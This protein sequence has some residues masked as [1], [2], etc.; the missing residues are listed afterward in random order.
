MN[1]KLFVVAT[2]IGNLSDITKRAV[3][4]LERVNCIA[5]EDTRETRG[6]LQKLHIDCDKTFISNNGYNEKT[7][8]DKVVSLLLEGNDVAVVSDAGMPGI[9]DPGAILVQAA[10]QAGIEVTGVCGASAVVTAVAVSGFV[11]SNSDFA[12]AGFFPR[13]KNEIEQKL[14]FALGTGI[15]TFVFYEAPLRITQT[16]E[17]IQSNMPEARLCLCNDL[18]KLYERIYRGSPEEVLAE[19]KNNPNAT[20][21]EYALVIDLSAVPV[22]EKNT[23]SGKNAETVLVE[24]LL[25]NKCTVKEAVTEAAACSNYSKNQLKAASFRL[26]ELLADENREGKKDV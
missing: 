21:G 6:L 16:V 19:L 26:K 5:A 10:S 2:P 18:T 15:S 17:I 12:F 1:G 11:K 8:K 9:S 22:P 4:V 7:V 20:K 23:V 13:K 3:E 25:E 24:Y 14:S